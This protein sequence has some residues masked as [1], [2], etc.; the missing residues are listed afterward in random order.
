MQQTLKDMLNDVLIEIG[1][2]PGTSVQV[3][4][5]DQVLNAINS[6]FTFVFEKRFW[7]HLTYTTEHTLDGAAGVIIDE[8]AAIEKF[9]DIQWIRADPYRKSDAIQYIDDEEDFED[10]PFSLCYTHLSDVHPQRK[11]KLIKVLPITQEGNIKIKARR[12]PDPFENDDDIIP[13]DS[14]CLRH[15]VIAT[16]LSADG[17][18]P[19]SQ[20]MQ[21]S[22]FNQ[23]YIDLVGQETNSISHFS[24]GRRSAHSFTVAE[25]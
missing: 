25:D 13:F 1:L 6:S 16:L 3:Y 11:T 17:M 8:V 24:T 19:S 23:R 21:Q 18:N 12:K 15:L 5:E 20:N 4:T 22:L 10:Q 9:T 14:T 2:V 7:K